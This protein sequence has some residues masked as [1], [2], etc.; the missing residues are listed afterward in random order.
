MRKQ[1]IPGP[2]P[3][4]KKWEPGYEATGLPSLPGLASLPG[5]LVTWRPSYLET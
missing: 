1:C 2:L 4:K 3:P 5:D